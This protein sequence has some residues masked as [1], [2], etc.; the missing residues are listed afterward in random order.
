MGVIRVVALCGSQAPQSST[1]SLLRVAATHAEL[2]GADVCFFRGEQLR[3]P[4]YGSPVDARDAAAVG[5]LLASVAAA[6]GVLLGSPSHHGS[7]SGLLKNAIDYLEGLRDH[8]N[9]YLTDKAVGCV[10][11]GAGTQG[12]VNTMRSLR[13]TVHSLRG[14][15][16]PLGVAVDRASAL[17]QGIPSPAVEHQLALVS[18]QVVEFALARRAGAGER[19]VGN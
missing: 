1:E 16:T 18:R 6:D 4:L 2:L 5:E 19:R 11:V 14:W 3:L 9:P 12:P 10:A 17:C 7:L 13:D 8:A 15:P